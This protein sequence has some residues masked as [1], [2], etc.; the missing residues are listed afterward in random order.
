MTGSTEWGTLTDYVTG[1]PLRPA[2]EA[3]WRKTADVLASGGP[4]SYP[5]AWD[6]EDGTTVWVDGGPE[7]QPDKSGISGAL[8]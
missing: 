6:D 1:E 2:T 8:Y 4:G 3:E 5:G 7:E